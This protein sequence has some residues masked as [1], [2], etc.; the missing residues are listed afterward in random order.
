VSE[1]RS[2]EEVLQTARLQ[3]DPLEDSAGGLIVEGAGDRKLWAPLCHLPKQVI[4]A[5]GKSLVC[6][7]H[8]AMRLGD[9]GRFVFVVDCDGDVERGVLEGRPDLVITEHAD[10]EGDLLAL[11]A[12]ELV[13][14]QLVP[15]VASGDKNAANVADA[16][17][18]K[19]V[20]LAEPVGRVRRAARARS[21]PLA[22]LKAW[23]VD[24]MAIAG[25][26]VSTVEAEALKQVARAAGLSQYQIRKIAE[27]LPETPSG[28]NVCNGH[29][30]VEAV[31]AVLV[32]DYKLAGASVRSVDSLMRMTMLDRGRREAWSVVKRLHG[33]EAHHGR[34]LLKS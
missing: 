14:E 18:A 6:E 15:A 34:K 22:S 28:L 7:A 4:I 27:G 29:D 20:A 33:W 17:S 13:V 16:V 2:G 9:T 26:S 11:G 32:A 5:G 21:I 19:T 31:Q 3:T 1:F 24:Y 8:G 10:V 23:E 30:L 12:L 25:A